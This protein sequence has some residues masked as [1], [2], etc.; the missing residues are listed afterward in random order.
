MF[1][2]ALRSDVVLAFLRRNSPSAG[3][4][5]RA[6]PANSSVS[7]GNGYVDVQCQCARDFRAY[8]GK[9]KEDPVDA[10]LFGLSPLKHR[11]ILLHRLY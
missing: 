6:N 7:S 1:L 5:V 2:F 8:V 9:S 3:A 4:G 11:N 10:R